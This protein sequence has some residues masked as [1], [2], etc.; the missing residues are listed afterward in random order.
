M[1]AEDRS[2]E[3]NRRW[4]T[5]TLAATHLSVAAD[6]APYS[7]SVIIWTRPDQVNP[8]D[9]REMDVFTGSLVIEKDKAALFA[10]DCVGSACLNKGSVLHIRGNLC[11]SLSV[12]DQCEIVI[13]GSVT[14]DAVIEAN[15]GCAVFVGGDFDGIIRS[16]DWLYCSINGNCRGIV[17]TGSPF[18]RVRV[19]GDFYCNLSPFLWA[20]PSYDSSPRARIGLLTL[21][22]YG[23]MAYA[24]LE[25]ISIYDYAWF[26]ATVATSDRGPGIF[27]QEAEGCRRPR[28]ERSCVWV[29]HELRK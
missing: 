7:S 4:E 8:W 24:A 18:T 19:A 29:I 1:N 14:P 13:G 11:G 27:P 16:K 28:S 2:A 6:F 5:V 15:G 12:A 20:D 26:R 21:E 3:L 9:L 10:D 17:R 22:V 25:A 23:F